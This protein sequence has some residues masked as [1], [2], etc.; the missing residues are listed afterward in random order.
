MRGHIDTNRGFSLIEVMVSLVV[1]LI[2][3]LLVVN[4]YSSTRE[5]HVR[6]DRVSE[7][8]ENGRYAMRQIANDL[9][10]AGFMGGVLDPKTIQID[11]TLSIASGDDC[12]NGAANWAIDTVNQEMIEF[13][14]QPSASSVASAHNCLSAANVQ[15]SRDVL[16]VKRVY[17]D[18]STGAL[19]PNT[20]YLRSDM[21]TGCLWYYST[22]TPAPTGTNC[23]T[24]GFDDW[25][26]VVDLYYIRKFAK[27]A[28]ENPL[29][30]TLCKRTLQPTTAASPVP[31]MATSDVCLAEGVERFHI[32]FG[33]DND[34]IPDGI[35]NQFDGAPSTADLKKSVSARIYVLVRALRTNDAYAVSKSYT[36]GTDTPITAGSDKYYRRVFGTTVLMR[37]RANLSN[38]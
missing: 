26:Y 31:S 22:S 20:V 29:V 38:M 30:P 25:R 16:V 19:T 33:V 17:G 32:D 14:H 1:G 2:S 8:L 18:K 7:A 37:N 23:P 28:T 15:D 3:L 13:M 36:L 24:S 11:S 21:T 10:A 6:G 35:A 9:Q 4:I 5:S 34:T 27:Y 12:G